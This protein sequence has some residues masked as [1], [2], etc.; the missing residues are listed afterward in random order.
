MTYLWNIYDFT[1]EWIHCDEVIIE[2]TPK[3]NDMKFFSKVKLVQ[4]GIMWLFKKDNAVISAPAEIV[5]DKH[6]RKYKHVLWKEYKMLI[7][8]GP[9]EE[10]ILVTRSQSNKPKGVNIPLH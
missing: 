5:H 3:N 9:T 8:S 10:D 4:E 7:N 1:N 6:P 2:Y